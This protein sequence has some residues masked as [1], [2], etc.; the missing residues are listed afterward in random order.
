M[1][2]GYKYCLSDDALAS[3]HPTQH[4]ALMAVWSVRRMGGIP[5]NYDIGRLYKALWAYARPCKCGD[6]RCPGELRDHMSDILFEGLG[7]EHE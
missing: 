3:L 4:H 5:S 6:K 2:M 1:A 7:R